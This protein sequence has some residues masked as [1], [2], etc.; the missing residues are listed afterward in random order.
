[1]D[2]SGFGGN[3]AASTATEIV[4][5]GVSVLRDTALGDEESRA[6]THPAGRSSGGG[7]I[8][9][10]AAGRDSSCGAS[11]VTRQPFSRLRARSKCFFAPSRLQFLSFQPP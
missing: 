9:D 11:S 7:A 6:L 10:P 5:R 4:K 8:A 3:F 1:M 2:I